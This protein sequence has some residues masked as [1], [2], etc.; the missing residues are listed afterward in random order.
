[1]N[2][3][4]PKKLYLSKWTA[5]QP[6]NKEKHFLVSKVIYSDPQQELIAESVELEAVFSKKIR[7]IPW[8]E[9]TDS[10]CWLQGW[11]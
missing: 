8:R 11:K 10:D 1:M 2:P 5:V 9:L 7:V 3:L 4:S 6:Q